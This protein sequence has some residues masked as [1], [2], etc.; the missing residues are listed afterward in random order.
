MNEAPS[1]RAL[2]YT[3]DA[4]FNSLV[5]SKLSKAGQFPLHCEANPAQNYTL[6]WRAESAV[7]IE[8]E[9]T[10]DDLTKSTF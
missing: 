9:E 4:D 7:D 10:D 8:D 6:R 1:R 3:I 2:T 5:D